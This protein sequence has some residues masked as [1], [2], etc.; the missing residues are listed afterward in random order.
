MLICQH[1]LIFLLLVYFYTVKISFK[2]DSCDGT[3]MS[4]TTISV[5]VASERIWTWAVSTYVSGAWYWL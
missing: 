4:L 5:S 1:L 2:V 3:V